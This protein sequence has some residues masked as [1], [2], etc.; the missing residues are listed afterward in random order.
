MG[1]GGDVSGF[2]ALKVSVEVSQLIKWVE[3]KIDRTTKRIDERL[4][5]FDKLAGDKE[6]MK[7][8]IENLAT[9]RH[10][11]TSNAPG[12]MARGS[13]EQARVAMLSRR[14]GELRQTKSGLINT[15]VGLKAHQGAKTM[16]IQLSLVQSLAPKDSFGEDADEE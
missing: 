15:L 16:E 1:Y 3:D 6:L 11:S 7:A 5:E 14:I 13:H 9:G 12:A 2:S 4:V 10:L 8:L